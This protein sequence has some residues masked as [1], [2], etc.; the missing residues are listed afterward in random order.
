MKNT[1]SSCSWE[2]TSSYGPDCRR[3]PVNNTGKRTWIEGIRTYEMKMIIINVMLTNFNDTMMI[4]TNISHTSRNTHGCQGGT[5]VE[6]M[7]T[8]IGHTIIDSN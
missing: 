1:T 7:A 6:S 4:D 3:I 2:S 8:N 5:V